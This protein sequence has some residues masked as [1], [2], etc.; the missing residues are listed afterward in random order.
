MKTA[1]IVNCKQV[2]TQNKHNMHKC[3]SA[4]DSAPRLGPAARGPMETS[5][6]WGYCLAQRRQDAR[7]RTDGPETDGWRRRWTSRRARAAARVCGRGGA[8]AAPPSSPVAPSRFKTPLATSG[9]IV[10]R[11][12]SLPRSRFSARGRPRACLW[13]AP[14]RFFPATSPCPVRR[15]A[16]GGTSPEN[17]AR[18]PVDR[19]GKWR[20]NY[21]TIC[22]IAARRRL[23]AAPT[24][25]ERHA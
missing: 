8:E 22:Q 3:G 9:L 10:A 25:G 21:A 14:R 19:R 23:I 20:V 2:Y 4:F 11:C 17:P 12:L 15:R 18:L 24:G 16:V 13:A 6:R 1:Q 5:V 7:R